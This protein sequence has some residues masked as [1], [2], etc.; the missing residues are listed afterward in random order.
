MDLQAP[1]LLGKMGGMTVVTVM[2]MVHQIADLLRLGLLL[3]VA[4]TAM[5]MGN[6]TAALL[7]GNNKLRHLLRVDMEATQATATVMATL[8]AWVLLQDW[9][10]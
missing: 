6:R 10:R 4:G 5:V 7:P 9:L 1:Q 2:I 8:R 3:G